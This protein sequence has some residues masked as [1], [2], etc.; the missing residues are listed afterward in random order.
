MYLADRAI[1]CFAYWTFQVVAHAW[2]KRKLSKYEV[3]NQTWVGDITYIRVDKCQWVY[4]AVAMD[5]YSR[6]IIGWSMNKRMRSSLVCDA[7]SMAL[8]NRSYPDNV[9]IHTDRDS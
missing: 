4:L 5:L 3:A 1:V 2:L 9:I 8:A 7:L 6:K